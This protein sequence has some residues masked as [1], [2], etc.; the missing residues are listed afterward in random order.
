M[1]FETGVSLAVV[2]IKPFIVEHRKYIFWDQKMVQCHKFEDWL[3]LNAPDMF[4]L[5]SKMSGSAMVT[6]P[7]GN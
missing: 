1:L 2:A 3:S 7:I 4:I 5:T 6:P